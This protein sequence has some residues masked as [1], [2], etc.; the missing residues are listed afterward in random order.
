MRSDPRMAAEQLQKISATAGSQRDRAR[1][2]IGWQAAFRHMDEA[3]AWFRLAGN[4]PLSDGSAAVVP[5]LPRSG[6]WNTVRTT[7]SQMSRL[8]AE[9]P[10]WIYWL[11]A[12]AVQPGAMRHGYSMPKC[13]ASRIFTAIWLTRNFGQ[14][15]TVPPQAAPPSSEEMLQAMGNPR[16]N[17]L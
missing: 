4:S 7:I 9:Q 12:P 8:L 5:V 2:Q 6:D 13:L 16:R 17:G 10:T 3:L 14:P 11:A 1:G 15:I